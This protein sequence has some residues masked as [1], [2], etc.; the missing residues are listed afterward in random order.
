[1]ALLT[2]QQTRDYLAA[3]ALQDYLLPEP[4]NPSG[5]DDLPVHRFFSLYTSL[6]AEPERCPS[7]SIGLFFAKLLCTFASNS[8]LS[9]EPFHVASCGE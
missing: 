9:Q 1:M 3:S 7:N 6:L 5:E 4:P 8:N 2:R